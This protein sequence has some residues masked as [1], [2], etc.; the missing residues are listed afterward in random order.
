MD[1]LHAARCPYTSVVDACLTRGWRSEFKNPPHDLD[2]R[3]VSPA[4]ARAAC[5]RTAQARRRLASVSLLLPLPASFP[6]FLLTVLRSV[7][8]SPFRACP[9]TCRSTRG[10]TTTVPTRVRPRAIP[11]AGRGE[12]ATRDLRRQRISAGRAAGS[13][14]S[15]LARPSRERHLEQ[16]QE[17]AET[18]AHRD[19][20][21]RR[22]RPSAVHDKSTVL[23]EARVFNQSPIS[24][25]ACRSL[26]ARIV[27][28]LYCGETFST[29]EATQLFFGV[30]KLFQHKDVRPAFFSASGSPPEPTASCS[31]H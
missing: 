22:R 5:E 2:G 28:L 10:M 17:A 13:P 7:K 25:R 4:R 20:D 29:Q 14:A 27:Y 21:H 24:P 16:R 30:T 3:R 1:V 26:L 31:R 8:S 18:R 11:R 19:A 12:Q 23:Q 9:A 6:T 15:R